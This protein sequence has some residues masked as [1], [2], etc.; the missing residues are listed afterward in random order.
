MK[1]GAFSCVPDISL[2]EFTLLFSTLQTH[3]LDEVAMVSNLQELDKLGFYDVAH[4]D[5]TTLVS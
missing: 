1:E 3:M 4:L 2:N 5:F